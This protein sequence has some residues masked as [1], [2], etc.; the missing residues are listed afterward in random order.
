MSK[1]LGFLILFF[2]AALNVQAQ[3]PFNGFVTKHHN[4]TSELEIVVFVPDNYSPKNT[5]PILYFNDGQGFEVGA[6]LSFEEL[7]ELIKLGEIEPMILVGIYTGGNR[8]QRYNPYLD[9]NIVKRNPEFT[10]LGDRY[11]RHVVNVL[12]PFME[13]RYSIRKSKVGMV[14]ISLGGLQVTW[15]MMKYPKTF[16]FIAA[17]SP[18]FWV[19]EF[20]INKEPLPE[21]LKDTRFYFDMGTG[22]WNYYL[23]LIQTMK[24]G[25]MQYGKELFYR[26]IPGARHINADWKNRMISIIR[27]FLLDEVGDPKRLTIEVECIPS[28]RTP[29]LF[30]QRINPV[31]YLKNEIPYSLAYEAN[32]KIIKG[33]GEVKEDGRFKV[34]E[35]NTMTVEVSYGKWV[36]KVKVKNCK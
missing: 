30:F 25:G 28:Q 3:R 22:E 7:G 12:L 26:E 33:V 34:T 31:V 13:K 36:K 20:A 24:K 16:S 11:S 8:R 1:S 2:L 19:K 9:S 10:P 4:I 5:Y 15:M 6:H 17:L 32:Y 14:G 29:G 27:L 21:N 18:A 23:P 35:G